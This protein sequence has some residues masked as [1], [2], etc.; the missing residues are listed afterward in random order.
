MSTEFTPTFG[1]SSKFEEAV[2]YQFLTDAG[3][4]AAKRILWI[5]NQQYHIE[6]SPLIPTLLCLLLLFLNEH[7]AFAVIRL[8]LD[9]SQKS[10]TAREIRWHFTLRK[11][12]FG[13]YLLLVLLPS[14]INAYL[15][16]YY[17][18]SRRKGRKNLEHFRKI[19]FEPRL[20]VDDLFATFF[21]EYV[22]FNVS[23]SSAGSCSSRS[24]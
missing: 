20:L 3:V 4:A 22:Q 8:L 21:L 23:D 18:L 11:I 14:L 16:S 17:K 13:R 10:N 2:R 15:E 7:E 1:D 9:R 12:D 24:L 5:I 6:F 19:G